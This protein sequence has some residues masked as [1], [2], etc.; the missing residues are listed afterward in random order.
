MDTLIKGK[1]TVI[2]QSTQSQ[3]TSLGNR[4]HYGLQWEDFRSEVFLFAL[5][6]P[7]VQTKDRG[8]THRLKTYFA[9]LRTESQIKVKTINKAVRRPCL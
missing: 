7:T 8:N 3:E 1:L 9:L 2:H 4:G 5:R 6:S